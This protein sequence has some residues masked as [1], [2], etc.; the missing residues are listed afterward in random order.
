MIATAIISCRKDIAPEIKGFVPIKQ[1]FYLVNEG[2]WGYNKASLDC[3]DFETGIYTNDIYSEINPDVALGLGDA[4]NDIKIYGSKLYI[5]VNGSNKVEILDTHTLKRVGKVNLN[6]CRYIT[7]YKNKAYVTSYDGLVAV[8]DTTNVNNIQK[9]IIVGRQ[10]EEMAVVGDKLYVANSG[11]YRTEPEKEYDRTVSVI[12]LNT[13]K[14]IKKIDVAIN[15]NKLR[16]DKYGNLY[17]TSRGDYL[18]IESSLYIIDTKT[19][20][21]SNLNIPV[22]NFYIQGDY[23]YLLSY[24]YIT[25]SATYL[26]FNIITKSIVSN[27]INDGTEAGI[28][29][30]YGIAVSPIN[31]D[32]YITDAKDFQNSGN[33]HIYSSSGTIKKTFKTGDIPAHFAFIN[34]H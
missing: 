34:N 7:F 21:V 26:K 16:A 27:I 25:N 1:G 18:D 6:N 32:I 30:P 12:D 14:E 20:N 11:G 8:I 2:N 24:S 28:T 9:T 23:A 31:G 10:P 33:L 5:V 17:V 19:D 22:S 4:A 3:Y 29:M 13:E 15:L